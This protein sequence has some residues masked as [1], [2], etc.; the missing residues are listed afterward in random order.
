MEV[1]IR[2]KLTSQFSDSEL[3]WI[4]QYFGGRSSNSLNIEG[5]SWDPSS[6]LSDLALKK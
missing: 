4:F 2:N 5:V 6:C 1:M 3:Q